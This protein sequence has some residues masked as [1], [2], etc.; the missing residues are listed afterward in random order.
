MSPVRR[1]RTWQTSSLRPFRLGGT[2]QRGRGLSSAI[3]L[4][5]LQ[6]R[7]SSS[8][9]ACSHGKYQCKAC[10]TPRWTPSWSWL[11]ADE[12]ASPAQWACCQKQCRMT[13]SCPAQ[14]SLKTR[15]RCRISPGCNRGWLAPKSATACTRLT[16]PSSREYPSASLFSTSRHRSHFVH[17]DSSMA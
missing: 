2:L 16:G 17:C 15:R 6:T 1:T 4:P 14:R 13:N 11:R 7:R 8:Q 3:L 5:S 12:S 9:H 10:Q